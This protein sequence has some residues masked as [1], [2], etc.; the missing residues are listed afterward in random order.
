MRIAVKAKPLRCRKA[1]R[2]GADSVYG[3]KEGP[4]WLC[5]D[6]SKIPP[7]WIPSLRETLRAVGVS[8]QTLGLLHAIGFLICPLRS[9]SRRIG[10][11]TQLVSNESTDTADGKQP[12]CHLRPSAW[13]ESGVPDYPWKVPYERHQGPLFTAGRVI[14]SR[15]V[16]L[17]DPGSGQSCDGYL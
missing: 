16:F 1:V 4:A 7:R 9:P 11:R 10:D 15:V 13:R 17:G 8:K 2:N 3:K 6:L 14:V 5:S 12:R